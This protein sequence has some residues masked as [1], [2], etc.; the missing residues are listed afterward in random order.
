[1]ICCIA[2]PFSRAEDNSL[3]ASE[4]QERETP[5]VVSAAL[6]MAVVFSCAMRLPHRQYAF[7]R[8]KRC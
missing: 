3:V 8:V 6:S 1:M 4:A 2:L 7:K 5:S